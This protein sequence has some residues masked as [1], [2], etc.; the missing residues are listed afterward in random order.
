VCPKNLGDVEE[1][2]LHSGS[3]LHATQLHFLS[4]PL[5]SLL[6]VL[7]S[8]VFALL[9]LGLLDL[10]EF[11][12][13]LHVIGVSAVS[14]VLGLWGDEEKGCIGECVCGVEGKGASGVCVWGGGEG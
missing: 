4:V 11:V 12:D 1:D 14:L 10:S 8:R 6:G 5:L 9:H 3:G 7:L 13:L 2:D